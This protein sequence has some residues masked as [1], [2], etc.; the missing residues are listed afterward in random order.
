MIE[1][2]GPILFEYYGGTEGGATMV[3]SHRWLERPGT[4]GQPW[5]G[6]TLSILDDDGNEC[7]TGVAGHHLPQDAVRRA[8]VPQRSRED[9]GGAPR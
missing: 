5:P 2:W 3:D 6:T 7:P 1:W 9:R 4:V 8:R